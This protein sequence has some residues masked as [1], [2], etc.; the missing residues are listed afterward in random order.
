M[1][2]S[3]L[4]WL[5]LWV[6]FLWAQRVSFLYAL[7]DLDFETAEKEIAAEWN[8]SYITWDQHRLAFFKALFPLHSAE[9]KAF[10]EITEHSERLF[11]RQIA[12]VL[13]ELTA[14]MY[15]QRAILHVLEENWLSAA[16]AAWRSWR[17]LQRAV[18]KD[19]LTHQWRG[20]WQ[21]I[22]ATLPPPYSDWLP[23]Q[24]ETRWQGA[25][26]ALRRA[27]APDSYTTWESSLLYFYVLR[28]LDTLA[29]AWLD[30]CRRYLF[31]QR[32]P[33]FLWRF[34]IGLYAFEEG[35]F[36]Q[37]ESLFVSLTRLPQTARF[38]YAYYWLG[39]LYLYVG[40][41]EA[42]QAAWYAFAEIQSQ[43]F[44][45]A[46]QEVWLG[47]IAWCKGDTA[48][49]YYLWR[50]ATARERLLW[51]ED[52][53][54]QSLARQW[55][56]NPP[57]SIEQRLWRARWQVHFRFFDDAQETLEPLRQQ[58]IRLTGDQ[59]TAL[60]YVYGRLYH[61]SRREEPARFAY[62]QATRQVSQKNRWMQAYAALYL[63]QLYERATDW[64][65]ARL[66]YKEA[67]RLGIETGRTGIVQKA[68]GG[69]ARVKDKRYPVVGESG[70][71]NR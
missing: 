18:E 63:A 69:Y 4:R 57:D 19:P 23:G 64:H 36:H 71:S 16:Y 21:V 68:R 61:R 32:E 7:W 52:L 35:Y 50:R 44:G 60:Y 24:I 62:Y 46:A 59:R 66:Y 6:S 40:W 48:Q 47:Y 25:L 45:M 31:S 11:E 51:E 67:E 26:T 58:A 5:S 39:K 33:P 20:L 28:N 54:A 38:P 12:P 29:A 30:T 70:K 14:D 34:S 42:A 41:W 17:H 9:R 2:A 22:F 10:W 65:N 13:P 15:A 53:L 1:R 8:G 27:A 37:A 55:L 49:A 56:E 3:T 43:P